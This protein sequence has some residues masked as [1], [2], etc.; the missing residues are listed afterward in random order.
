MSGPFN[1]I[2]PAGQTTASFDIPIIDDNI[3]EQTETFMLSI[4]QSSLPDRIAISYPRNSTVFIKDD[5][6]CKHI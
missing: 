2:I 1:V 6:D 3:Y 4:D 5:G